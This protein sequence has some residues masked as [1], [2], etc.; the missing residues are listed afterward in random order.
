MNNINIPEIF[1]SLVFNETVMKERLPDDV[2]EIV[3]K[4]LTVGKR[5]TLEVANVVADAMKNWAHG[6]N[7]LHLA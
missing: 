5:M 6:Q 7:G 2:F 1:G 3:N 4:T